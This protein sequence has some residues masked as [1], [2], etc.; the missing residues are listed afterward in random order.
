[1][2]Q[3]GGGQCRW[4]GKG[5]LQRWH[6]PPLSVRVD[7][8]L[9]A[10]KSKSTP[11]SRSPLYG[12]QLSDLPLNTNGKSG[13][14]TAAFAGGAEA[15]EGCMERAWEGRLRDRLGPQVLAAQT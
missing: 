11:Q 4:L 12:C 1:M 3:P 13:L 14:G 9:P 2:E 5:F 7:R 15:A 6:S 8:S 10:A